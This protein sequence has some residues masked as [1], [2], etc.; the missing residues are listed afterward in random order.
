MT[1]TSSH[2]VV[3]QIQANLTVA[4]G[5]TTATIKITIVD[6]EKATLGPKL[7]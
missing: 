4:A 3:T 6:P 1:L 2:S 5:A 7:K